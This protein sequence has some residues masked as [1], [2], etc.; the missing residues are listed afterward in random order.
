MPLSPPLR[1]EDFAGIFLFSTTVTVSRDVWT[2]MLSQCPFP[3]RYASRT[4]R[5]FFF[6]QR[7][8][9]ET[10]PFHRS[11]CRNAPFPSA[12]RRGLRGHFSFLN[13]VVANGMGYYVCTSRNAPSG[14]FLF[15]TCAHCCVKG[16][17]SLIAMPLR[18]FFFSQPNARTFI[19]N[20]H[21]V[22]MP[23]RAFFFSQPGN[24]SSSA[25]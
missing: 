2:F 24:T 11:V 9:M 23:L 8:G 19:V 22:A 3:L 4:S 18:A 17:S 21:D 5:A 14:I 25:R 16:D 15:S 12:T 20:V 6:S 7:T 13:D 1:V 10:A